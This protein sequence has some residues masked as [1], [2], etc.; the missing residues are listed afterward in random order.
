MSTQEHNEGDLPAIMRLCGHLQADSSSHI[1]LGR[2][3]QLC[4]ASDG[5]SLAI[6]AQ[7]I[8]RCCRAQAD[9]AL[10]AALSDL[11]DTATDNPELSRY[12]QHAMNAIIS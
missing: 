5:G 12:L 2:M 8:S 10:F 6:I 1:V 7:A 4:P 11:H 3:L 9:V